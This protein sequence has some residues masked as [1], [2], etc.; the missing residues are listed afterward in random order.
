MIPVTKPFLP[1][2]EEYDAYVDGIWE[3]NWLTNNGPLVNELELRLKEYLEVPNLLYVSNGTIA[4]QLAIKALDL[5][6]EI[7]TTPFSY[8]ATTSSIVWEG[9]TPVF[10]DIDPNTLNID[11]TKIEAAITS[12]TSAILAT[13][14]YGNPCDIDAIQT[15]ADKHNLKVI[16]DAAHCFGTLY[17]GKSVF[18]YGDV[19]TASFHATKV[20]HTIEGGAVF[21]RDP[22]VLKRM[23]YM[24][25]FGH[26]GP[27]KFSGVGINGKNSEFHAAMGLVNLKYVDEVLEER[28]RISHYYDQALNGF[29][30][31]KPVITAS[32]EFNYAYY[33]LVLESEELLKKVFEKLNRR[34]IFPRRYFYPSLDTLDYVKEGNVPQTRDVSKKMICL[35]V[36][37][38]LSNVE[39]S[40]VCRQMKS[41]L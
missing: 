32:A 37:S 5:K 16:Y 12:K 7:I 1:P 2:R 38:G 8:V 24:R 10:T 39:I 30:A 34:E 17:K 41:V 22:E 28:K 20:F 19:S 6:G 29:P 3:R 18:A 15:I 21:A 40:L 36:F 25:N 26:D 14:V 33:P 9:C 31:R 13:H 23:S 11:P 27:E 4:L 35:P